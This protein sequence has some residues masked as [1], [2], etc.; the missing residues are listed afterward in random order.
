[1]SVPAADLPKQGNK[2]IVQC[3]ESALFTEEPF[4]WCFSDKIPTEATD[5]H[6]ELWC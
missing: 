4:H 5:S 3:R 2:K 1:M 6:L